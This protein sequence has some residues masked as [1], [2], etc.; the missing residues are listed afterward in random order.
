M[1]LVTKLIGKNGLSHMLISCLAFLAFYV[2][3]Q[4]FEP[5]WVTYFMAVPA[6]VLLGLIA[7]GRANAIEREDTGAPWT[8]RRAGLAMVAGACTFLVMWPLIGGTPITWRLVL[9]INGFAFVWATT[10]NQ[11]PLQDW[12]FGK[13]KI[14]RS[15][16]AAA[17]DLHG[18]VTG[19]YPALRD[20]K[21]A[22]QQPDPG[23]DT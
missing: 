18:R 13:V 7:V 15:P 16:L 23:S 9:F 21:V 6:A 20:V 14:P 10:P 2:L 19:Q 22:T 1:S 5:G 3:T 17:A 11:P 8:F 4:L 12:V